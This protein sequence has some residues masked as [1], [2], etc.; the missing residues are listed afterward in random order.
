ML[1]PTL[2]STPV[3]H[4]CLGVE[5]FNRVYSLLR[6]SLI[7]SRIDYTACNSLFLNLSSYQLNRLL[8]LSNPASPFLRHCA[9]LN[10]NASRYRPY[11]T[12]ARKKG[13]GPM[14]RGALEA[15]WTSAK[16]PIIWAK[17]GRLSRKMFNFNFLLQIM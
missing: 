7:N 8:L 3:I 15:M 9:Q 6:T 1:R 4:L 11:R 12:S 13:V 14:W 16:P 10:A 2:L 5:T 17:I